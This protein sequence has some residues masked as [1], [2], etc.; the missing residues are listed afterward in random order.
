MTA[1]HDDRQTEAEHVD[2]EHTDEQDFAL[3]NVA[4]SNALPGSAQPAAGAIVGSEG[5]LGMQPE[6]DEEIVG[7]DEDRAAAVESDTSRR[8]ESGPV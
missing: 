5:R 7:G 2:P 8:D 3:R 4:M 6:T 1:D